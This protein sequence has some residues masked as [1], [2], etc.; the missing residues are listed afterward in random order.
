MEIRL[1]LDVPLV[2]TALVIVLGVLIQGGL[3]AQIIP[4]GS[5]LL[6]LWAPVTLTPTPHL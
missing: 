2:T 6:V 3:E 1:K 5:G 4:A